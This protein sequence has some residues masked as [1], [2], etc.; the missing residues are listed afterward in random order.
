MFLSCVRRN[1]ARAAKCSSRSPCRK[2]WVVVLSPLIEVS[3][4]A[5]FAAPE[6]TR[7]SESAKMAVFSEGYGR[8]DLQ[9]VVAARFPEVAACVAALS[10]AAPAEMPEKRL[11]LLLAR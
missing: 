5:V 3:T 2:S 9:V 8:N 10:C 7:H 4:K 1:G 6:L 11:D